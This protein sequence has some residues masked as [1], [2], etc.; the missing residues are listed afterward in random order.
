MPFPT[1]H[2]S[3]LA[4]AT[5]NSDLPARRALDELCRRY[6]SPLK[7]FIRWRGY[8]EADAEDLTQEFILY[9]LEHSTLNAVDRQKGLF[10]SFLLGALTRFLCDDFD[11]RNA[12]KR[13]KGV[14]HVSVDVVDVPAANATDSDS[15]DREWALVILENVFQQVQKEFER[16]EALNRFAVL[17]NYLPGAIETPSY[18]AAAAELALSVPAVTSEVHRMRQR[19]KVLLREEVAR[20]VSS[21]HELAGEMAYLRTVLM[22]RGNDLGPSQKGLHANS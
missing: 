18:E 16:D 15:F 5:L 8:N 22:D 10:R 2:W 19:F 6:W 13:G 21:P 17:R 14:T 1:T 12:L 9:L 4:K 20:T 11:R 7:Q 3:A